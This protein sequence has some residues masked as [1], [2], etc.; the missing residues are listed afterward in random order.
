MKNV[1]I[2]YQCDYCKNM[3]DQDDEPVLAVMP[4]RIGYRDQ[5]IPDQGD[6]KIQHYHD[7]C[8][9][10]LLSSSFDTD[11]KQK[12]PVTEPK[13]QKSEP[14]EKEERKKD[15]G[16]LKSLLNAGWTKPKIADDFGV[17]TATIYNWIKEITE[18]G[19]TK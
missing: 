3:I 17:S 19:E 1:K 5:F 16:K 7:Y 12:E 11:E 15:L 4:G 6:E 14:S 13:K 18:G 10:H 8:L 2:T 9:K